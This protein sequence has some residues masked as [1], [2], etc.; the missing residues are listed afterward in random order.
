MALPLEFPISPLAPSSILS[1]RPEI[2][3]RPNLRSLP[4]PLT[5][6]VSQALPILLPNTLWTLPFPIAVTLPESGACP[7]FLGHHISV[8]TS[9]C[10][11]QIL[12]GPTSK[13]LRSVSGAAARS[14]ELV[15]KCPSPFPCG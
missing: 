2:P 1:P 15:C 14:L 6:F 7:L 5:V 4:H 8:V 11:A 13:C 12:Q 3:G 9:R 10:A